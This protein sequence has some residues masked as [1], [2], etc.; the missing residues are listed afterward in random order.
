MSGETVGFLDPHETYFEDESRKRGVSGKRYYFEE[1]LLRHVSKDQFSPFHGIFGCDLD[2]ANSYDGTLFRFPLRTTP[3]ELSKKKYTKEMIDNLFHSL[4]EEAS[5]ILLFLKSV[6][7]IKVFQRNQD[8]QIEC[9]LKV[10][11]AGDLREDVRRKRKEFLNKATEPTITESRYI[12]NIQVTFDSKT[13]NF[14][15]LTVNQIGSTEERI[16]ELAD[17]LCLLP[18][19]G[20][21]VPI[22]VETNNASLGRIFCFLPLPPDVDC[23]TGLPVHVHGYFGLTDNRRGLVWPGAECQNT[24]TAEWNELLL[25]KIAVEVYCKMV[26]ALIQ[27]IPCT[28]IGQEQR[29]QLIYS[30]LPDLAK[31]QGHWKVLLKPLF[32]ELIQY[33]VLLLDFIQQDNP[34][35]EPITR[36]LSNILKQYKEGVSV[37]KELIQNADDAGAT[38]VRFLVDWRQG[39]KQKLLSPNMEHCQGPALWAYNDAVFTDKDF[40]NINKLAGATKVEDLAKIGRFGLG[41]NAVYHLTDVPSFMSGEHVV[42]FDPNVNHLESHI[43]DKSRPGIRIN[44]A[45]N[46]RPL[47]AFVDQ[48]KPYHDVFGCKTEGIM[49]GEKFHYDGTLFRFPFRTLHEAERSEICKSVYDEVKVQKMV[50]SLQENA[51]LLLL[52]T[53]HVKVVE[54]HQVGREESPRDMKLVLPIARRETE[55]IHTTGASTNLPFIENVRNGGRRS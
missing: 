27:D 26:E 55:S 18:W 12:M 51:S 52:Y 50:A 9:V 42:I 36:R 34:T 40:E 24:A 7:S 54:L 14:S 44:L 46:P 25:K 49:E 28:G 13:E 45:S 17:E 11:V 19:V 8:G 5:V 6:Q 16:A 37:L 32:Q 48:F 53:Q 31:V 43:H 3:S 1:N 33:D 29:R 41:F 4:R 38:K 30:R 15:W 21:A 23:H 10:E 22:A 39:P 20:I 35:D 47:S 2:T